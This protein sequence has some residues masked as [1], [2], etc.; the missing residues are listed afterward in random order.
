M[1]VILVIYINDLQISFN[2]MLNIPNHPGKEFSIS[3]T[4]V[5]QK[6][7]ESIMGSNPSYHIKKRNPVENASWYDAIYF[8][9]KLSEAKWKTPVYSVNGN[10]DFRKWNYVPH[11]GDSLETVTWN[12]NADVYRLPT[13]EEWEYTAMGVPYYATNK[14]LR[15]Y[16]GSDYIGNVGWYV[17]NSKDTTHPVAKKKANGFGMYDMTGNVW[18]WCWDFDPNGNGRSI[19]GGSY[20]SSIGNCDVKCKIYEKP[21]KGYSNIGFRVVGPVINS[22]ETYKEKKI[23]K[24]TALNVREDAGTEYPVKFTIPKGT[25]VYLT[26]PKE[27]KNK[28]WVKIKCDKGYGWVNSTLLTDY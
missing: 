16:S 21:N 2:K 11:N 26:N 27:I 5:T 23:V 7:Y 8:C 14:N 28:C 15:T 24:P 10:T 12:R 20:T 3:N 25:V 18:E 22:K 4:E 17:G 13:E 6:L 9:N 1:I 19:R